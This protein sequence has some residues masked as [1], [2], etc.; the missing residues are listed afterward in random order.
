[1]ISIPRARAAA[2]TSAHWPKK[3]YWANWH[4][5]MAPASF[6]RSGDFFARAQSRASAGHSHQAAPAKWSLSAWKRA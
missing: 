5:S 6:A 3:R 1:M 2:R 4:A